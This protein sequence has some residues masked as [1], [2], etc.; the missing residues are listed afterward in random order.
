MAKY[1]IM[2]TWLKSNGSARIRAPFTA[3]DEI[4]SGGLPKSARTNEAWWLGEA[5]ASP[6]HV[7]KKGWEAAGYKVESVH[8]EVGVVTFSR[9]P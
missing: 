8:I 1:D 3:L 4:L 2:T 5:A 6:S 9:Q 7:Q